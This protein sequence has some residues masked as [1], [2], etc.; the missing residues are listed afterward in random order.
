[1]KNLL[2]LSGCRHG[3]CVGVKLKRNLD[4]L[5]LKN[6]KL[7]KIFVSEPQLVFIGKPQDVY[8]G[9]TE[10]VFTSKRKKI[11]TFKFLHTS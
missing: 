2:K 1:M 9:E 11:Q 10:K 3:C 8:V 4:Q 6:F 5:I 7:L